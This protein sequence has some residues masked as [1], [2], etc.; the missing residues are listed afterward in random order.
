[1]L[2]I[3]KTAYKNR[4]IN[5]QQFK[6]MLIDNG[7]SLRLKQSNMLNSS[8]RLLVSFSLCAVLK[9]ERL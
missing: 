8:I 5:Q 7:K 2:K 3:A 6:K 9:S 4:T 1:M